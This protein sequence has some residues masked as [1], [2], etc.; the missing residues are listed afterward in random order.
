MRSGI[1]IGEQRAARGE[2]ASVLVRE[3][4][5]QRVVLDAGESLMPRREAALKP[6]R[7]HSIVRG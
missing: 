4:R 6:R 2:L 5:G 1:G 3:S 7:F